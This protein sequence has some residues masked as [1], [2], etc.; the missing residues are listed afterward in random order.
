MNFFRKQ[1]KK[2]SVNSSRLFIKNEKAGF[3]AVYLCT[4]NVV[5]TT[6]VYMVKPLQ[7]LLFML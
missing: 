1:P 2:L 6:Y 3:F 4:A 7:Y 5:L